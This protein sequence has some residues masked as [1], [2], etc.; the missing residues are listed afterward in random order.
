MHEGTSLAEE[1]PFDAAAHFVCALL[2]PAPLGVMVLDGAGKCVA[3][4]ATLDTLAR[5]AV[6]SRKLDGVPLGLGTAE[7][8]SAFS[9][10]LRGEVAM[11]ESDAPPLL[12]SG[13]GVWRVHFLPF[14]VSDARGAAI[15]FEDV[16][17]SRLATEA[18]QAAEQRFRT[19]V[20]SAVDG[21]LIFRSQIL[22]YVNPEAV[23]LFGFQSPDELVGRPL[24]DLIDVE[25]RPNF[26]I[27][28]T[29]A[30]RGTHVFETAFLRRDGT[31]FPVEC[32]SSQA[33]IDEMGAGF[34]FFRDI[35]E[36]KR[37]QARRENARRVESLARLSMS[38]GD[39]L[40]GH[41]ATLRRCV[42]DA[43]AACGA[44]SHDALSELSAVVD[45]IAA[46]ARELSLPRVPELSRTA[47]ASLE[48]VVARICTGVSPSAAMLTTS[49]TQPELLVDIEPARFALRG[50]SGVIETGLSRL[51]TAVM[52]SRT[53]RLPVRIS[54]S[55]TA[56]S[57][58][59]QSAS[60]RLAI[61][62]GKPK[63]QASASAHLSPAFVHA[64]ATFASWE[65]GQNLG[66]LG[67]FSMLQS[68]GCWVEVQTSSGGALSFDVELPLDPGRSSDGEP[69]ESMLANVASAPDTTAKQPVLGGMESSPDTERSLSSASGV[70][71]DRAV[72]P[73]LICD[74]EARLVALTAGLLREFGFDVLTVRSGHE[75][76]RL[77]GN[78]PID[79]VILDVNL[80]GED[81][82]D[83]IEQLQSRSAVSIILSSGYTEEDIEPALLHHAAV[84]AFL[85][86]PYGVETLVNTIDRV[87]LEASEVTPFGNGDG[88]VHP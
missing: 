49:T 23:R 84:K 75:A 46:R 14:V 29:D 80:P 41:V 31:T 74:D 28:L 35:T 21:I 81:A 47:S 57:V 67:A 48:E 30:E 66:L 76:V 3:T 9:R 13:Q 7:L 51:V 19:L 71:H 83:V 85:A 68:Q 64:I 24:L 55:R 6:E 20:D 86:K 40:G 69:D 1:G 37:H 87:R 58:N 33:R 43:S 16:T 5:Q 82:K 42:S 59:R 60:Y 78:H 44:Q 63:W 77:I 25:H 79:V 32:S 11:V 4:N 62:F 54:G 50:D 72:A 73:V 10:A 17:E 70:R 56:S 34:L 65:Q 15:L 45:A 36:R 27:R 61:T 22:L 38:L 53:E 18:F 12:G 26:D 88:E 2:G 8:N 52:Q 39:E